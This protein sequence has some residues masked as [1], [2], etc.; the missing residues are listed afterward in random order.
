[1]SEKQMYKYLKDALFGYHQDEIELQ[2]QFLVPKMI[3]RYHLDKNK[4]K[5]LYQKTQ[6][7]VN[8]TT[9][10]T[11]T[12]TT[13]EAEKILNNIETTLTNYVLLQCV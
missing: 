4:R 11:K 7:I 1:M 2:A 3:R 10:A 12:Y 6:S 13:A 5:L 9:D 8:E